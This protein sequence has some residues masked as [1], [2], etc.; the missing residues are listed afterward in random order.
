[1][2]G[3]HWWGSPEVLPGPARPWGTASG[4]FPKAASRPQVPVGSGHPKR[5]QPPQSLLPAAR[6]ASAAPCGHFLA[7]RGV[8][9]VKAGGLRLSTTARGTL[10]PPG[11]WDPH[12]DLRTGCCLPVQC[13]TQMCE[14]QPRARAARP[15]GL[16]ALVP[17]PGSSLWFER[18]WEDSVRTPRGPAPHSLHAWWGHGWRM[19]HRPRR[20]SGAW[21]SRGCGAMSVSSSSAGS[22][23]GCSKPCPAPKRLFSEGVMQGPWG[24]GAGKGAGQEGVP[25][26]SPSAV[27]NGR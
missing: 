3:G 5:L 21:G 22:F 6:R 19:R 15:H 17:S 1:M 16:R 14:E 7:A 9:V 23:P 8:E 11:W 26:A 25:A 2:G 18:S 20:S 27:L 12:A 10:H 13:Q 4:R 24:R